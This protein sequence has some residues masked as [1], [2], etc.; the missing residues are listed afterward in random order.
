MYTRFYIQH[1]CE[2][3][4]EQYQLLF[5]PNCITLLAPIQF[6]AHYDPQI[7]VCSPTSYSPFCCCAFNLL[8]LNFQPV[9]YRTIPQFIKSILNSNLVRQSA[10]NRP[11]LLWLIKWVRSRIHPCNQD[12]IKSLEKKSPGKQNIILHVYNSPSICLV[13]FWTGILLAFSKE[14]SPDSPFEEKGHE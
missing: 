2:Y 5:F 12:Y 7:L 3:T 14:S 10:C 8:L 13:A 9:D 4:S 6:V 1:F 11:G